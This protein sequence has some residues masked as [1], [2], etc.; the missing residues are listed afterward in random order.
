MYRFP[1]T[2]SHYFDDCDCF[3]SF[4][5][6]FSLECV[7][8]QTHSLGEVLERGCMV[9]LI[10]GNIFQRSPKL[11]CNQSTNWRSESVAK[12]SQKG[13]RLFK[14]LQRQNGCIPKCAEIFQKELP[15]SI[16]RC[17]KLYLGWFF[18]LYIEKTLMLLSN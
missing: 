10:G 17:P 11:C 7:W 12:L 8:S 6:P 5:A 1:L 9:L 18:S 15:I 4:Y 3:I 2:V 14:I 16:F 13:A